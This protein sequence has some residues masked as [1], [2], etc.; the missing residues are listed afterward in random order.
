AVATSGVAASPVVSTIGAGSS[1]PPH[2]AMIPSTTAAL[3]K[4]TI[5]LLSIADVHVAPTGGRSMYAAFHSRTRIIDPS[6]G[7]IQVKVHAPA[8]APANRMCQIRAEQ[9][10]EQTRSYADRYQ[11][12]R[13]GE[14]AARP[15]PPGIREE[16]G[17]N[18]REVAGDFTSNSPE[19]LAPDPG[20]RAK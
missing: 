13:A 7:C 17:A 16:H 19:R 8:T 11:G 5:I 6:E 4:R 12:G 9:P 3:A 15:G 2:P 18:G 20:G 14:F 10:V 1:A